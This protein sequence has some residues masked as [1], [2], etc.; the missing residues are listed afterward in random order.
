[1]NKALQILL[2]FLG[3][4]L[5]IMFIGD[6][7]MQIGYFSVFIFTV[8]VCIIIVFFI[9]ISDRDDVNEVDQVVEDRE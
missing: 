4:G 5:S 8:V 9:A 1:M 3:A 6:I 2:L 7:F